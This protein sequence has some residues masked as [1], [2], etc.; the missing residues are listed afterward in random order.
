[1]SLWRITIRTG[2]RASKRKRPRKKTGGGRYRMRLG[3]VALVLVGA[4]LLYLHVSLA[5]RFEGRLWM[6]PSRIY[7]DVLAVSAGDPLTAA[8]LA[9]RLDRSGYARTAGSPRR[10]G[11]YQHDETALDVHLRA[12]RAAGFR[13]GARRL[14]LRFRGGR[15]RSIA[16]GAGRAV[17]R[18]VFEPEL[19]ATLFGPRQEER[20]PVRLDEVPER[21]REAVLAAEDARFFEH[22]GLEPRGI[23]RASWANLRHGRIVQGGSTITQQTVKN[24]FLGQQRTWWRKAREG[25]LSVMLDAAYAKDRILEV[26]LNEVYL[27]Q[28]GPVA[29]CGVQAASRFYFGR[30]V[31][32][33]SLG[34]SA[35]VAGLIRSPGRYNP[36]A[37]RDRALQR[38]DR[39]LERM[40]RL[41]LITDAQA[42][43]A[44][45]ERLELASG[46]GGFAS[47]PYAVD[48]VRDRLAELYSRETLRW[49]GLRIYTTLDTSWQEHAEAALREG[50]ERL[51][52]GGRIERGGPL[53]GVVLVLDPQSGAV[54]AMVGG[55]DYGGSQFN[56]A[57]QARRQPGS[58]FKP[59]VY[60]AGFENAVRGEG[61]ELTPA[62]LLDDS[63]LEM[64]SGGK[65]WRPANYDGEHRGWVT[66]RTALEQ[67]LNVPTIRAARRV[68]LDRVVDISRRMGIESSLK[69]LP[70]LALG[71]IE[72]TPLDVAAAYATLARLGRASRPWVVREIVDDEGNVLVR[73]RVESS[74]GVSPQAAYLI[75]HLL[76]GVLR[77][78]TARS[79]AS[80]GYG[81]RASGK[82]GT[83]DD[84]RDAWF[85]GYT[86][87]WLSLVWVG[88]DDN[89]ATGLTG[90]T[91]ALPIWVDLMKRAG[92]DDPFARDTVPSG[93][94]ERRIDA[95]TGDLVRRGCARW[96]DERFAEGTEPR[97]RCV[98]HGGRFRR[99]FHKMRGTPPYAADDG[100]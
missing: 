31:A 75:N 23:L 11:Q 3:I 68:G 42:G 37:H 76:R 89:S 25:L 6:L 99:W 84:T 70:S 8:G 29:I 57:T 24:I 91:G 52:R 66:V 96:V 16:D 21:L 38:R 98:V 20:Q 95:E 59:F 50:L 55:R 60:A 83:T 34:E 14:R 47:A 90:A 22:Y 81:G 30:D 94:V 2:K 4:G 86:S 10:P 72:M 78:G 27:G 44:R 48:F 9:R 93:I 53:Q 88:R 18:A 54:R 41:G 39:V 40:L 17:E 97:R 79:A 26:Y 74:E 45:A 77:H 28:R 100:V 35:L 67:S 62:T 92:A 13:E 46:R 43:A 51:E 64:R 87:E 65:M 58:C 56:R 61:K 32:D 63:P 7:S 73:P 15:L 82:T 5:R 12:F 1:M 33:L 85:V 19:L 36:F 49:E 69:P 80:L 71:A